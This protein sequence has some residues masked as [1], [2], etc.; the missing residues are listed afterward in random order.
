MIEKY[1]F[2]SSQLK[3]NFYVRYLH[4]VRFHQGNDYLYQILCSL[5]EFFKEKFQEEE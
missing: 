3:M 4:N 1:K 2:H 5:L